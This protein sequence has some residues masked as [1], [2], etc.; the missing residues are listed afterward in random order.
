ME[1]KYE[2]EEHSLKAGAMAAESIEAFLEKG[3]TLRLACIKPNG[4]PFIIPCW[5]QWEKKEGCTHDKDCLLY[6]S[7][8]PRDR[9]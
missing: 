5:H 6:T 3:M 1:K 8:S 9:G 4:D 2:D 7:P